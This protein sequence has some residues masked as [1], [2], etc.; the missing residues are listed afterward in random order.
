MKI[1]GVPRP[2]FLA[3]CLL[4][5]FLLPG[6]AESVYKVKKKPEAET[7]EFKNPQEEKAY[8]LRQGEIFTDGGYLKEGVWGQMEGVIEAPT[9]LVWRLYIQANDWKRY[10]LPSL[11][12]SRAV[13]QEVTELAAKDEKVEHFYKALGNR[14]FDPNSWRRKGEKWVNF[15][16][17]YFNIPWPVADRWYVVR[18]LND[19]TKSGTGIYRAEFTRA[20]GNIRTLEGTIQFEPF[21]GDRN[22]TRMEYHVRSDPG[23]FVPRFLVKWGVRKTM[24][25][26]IRAI[27]REAARVQGRQPLLLKTQ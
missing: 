24:P 22:L 1:G 7:P 8:R 11:I 25:G 12:D 5:L 18:T 2:F 15:S 16:F 19:E 9:D 26:S 27:R 3:I 4:T 6:H 14:F 17:Q 23:S 13:S 10:G 21:Q 20:A